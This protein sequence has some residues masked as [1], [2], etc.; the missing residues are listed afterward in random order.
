MRDASPCSMGGVALAVTL[1]VTAVAAGLQTSRGTRVA[2]SPTL[3]AA[4]PRDERTVVLF[5]GGTFDRWQDRAGAASGWVVQDDGSIEVRGGDAV[6]RDVFRDFQLHLEFLC[7]PVPDKT[8]QARANS[9]VYLHGRYE[10]QILDSADR[11]PFPS[12]CGAIYSIAQPLVNA[13]RP[14]GAWRDGRR[15][16]ARGRAARRTG[17]ARVA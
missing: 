10:V 9:G 2:A 4:A 1:L 12:G 14:A 13:S 5:D 6:T 15:G 16:G 11:P 8:G 7:P 3:E 17:R